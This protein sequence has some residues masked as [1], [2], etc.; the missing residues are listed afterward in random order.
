VIGQRVDDLGI[1]EQ[2]A[3]TLVDQRHPHAERGKMLLAYSQPITPAREVA[4]SERGQRSS[5]VGTSLPSNRM[6][7]S[8]V[9]RCRSR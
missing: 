7:L 4:T 8:H 3:V 1:D 6:W 5:P 9:F 2:E